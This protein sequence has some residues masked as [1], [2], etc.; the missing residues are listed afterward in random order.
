MR[1]PVPAQSDAPET[2]DL[3][4]KIV[5]NVNPEWVKSDPFPGAE[6]KDCFIN[7]ERAIEKN[8]GRAVNGW[9]IWQVPGVFIEAEFHCV[10]E[11]ESGVMLNVTPY[12]NRPDKILFLP[13]HTRV[14]TGKQLDNVRQPLVNDPDVIRWLYLARRRF[15]ILNTGDLANQYGQIELPPKLSKEFDKIITETQRLYSRLQRRYS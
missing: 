15:E 1:H 2:L 14:Y 5:P 10:W 12:P 9:T 4:Q 8:G 6:E 7:V 13:D 3:C 11:K